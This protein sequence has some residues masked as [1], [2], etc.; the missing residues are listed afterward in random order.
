MLDAVRHGDD[1]T[2]LQPEAI[3]DDPSPR[4]SKYV[5]TNWTKLC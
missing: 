1:Q 5:D 2:C 3:Y 4:Q